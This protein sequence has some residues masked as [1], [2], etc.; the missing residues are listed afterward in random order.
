MNSRPY[1]KKTFTFA[2]LFFASLFVFA[3]DWPVRQGRLIANFG[4]NDNGIPLLGDSFLASGSIFPSNVGELV[5]I[6]DPEN[7]AARLPSP[8]GSWMA[9]DHGDNL[10]G[11]YGRYEDRHLI[12]L[13][14]LVETTT[15]L[16]SAGKSGWTGSNGVYFGFFDRRERR[17]VNPSVIISSVQ[18]D[19][20][21]VIRQVELRN[22]A[23]T[24]V[25][26]SVTSIIPQGLYRIYVDV[27]DTLQPGGEYLAPN[28]ITYSING[29]E[30]AT[31][32]FETL[33]SRDGK[34][35]VYRNGLVTAASVYDPK[36]FCLGEIRL[37][38]GQALLVIETRDVADNVR[39]VVYRLT[40][41]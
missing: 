39:S 25:N 40:I 15:V 1:L 23:G 8:L 32:S 4:K 35:M 33:M 12:P 16:A 5:F 22:A 41:D 21:P 13:P 38:R 29:A 31:L 19:V 37:T 11:L 34:N 14:A 24:P 30:M 36:G 9:I 18:D 7:P 17:W 26:P 6:H 3:F 28:R 10:V 20:P 2:S 27:I